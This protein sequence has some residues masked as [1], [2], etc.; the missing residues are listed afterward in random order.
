MN[1]NTYFKL[2]DQYIGA[3][4]LVPE[5]YKQ[6]K[7][8]FPKLEDAIRFSYNNSSSDD[9]YD[10]YGEYDYQDKK[11]IDRYFIKNDVNYLKQNILCNAFKTIKSCLSYKSRDGLVK[12]S[13]I[14]KSKIIQSYKTF[15][16]DVIIE[17]SDLYNNCGWYHFN[18]YI[19]PRLWGMVLN[20]TIAYIIKPISYLLILFENKRL[21]IKGEPFDFRDY[22]DTWFRYYDSYS[23]D[24]L[25]KE[26]ISN[27]KLANKL[28]SKIIKKYEKNLEDPTAEKLNQEWLQE[29]KKKG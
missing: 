22:E 13:D 8:D 25:P 18:K 14:N 16:F 10:N 20:Y 6:I 9:I 2:F 5:L 19:K 1:E 15:F 17:E 24:A 3:P 26:M 28:Y 21:P 27:P 11:L 29:F 7:K 12:K 4:K 23:G